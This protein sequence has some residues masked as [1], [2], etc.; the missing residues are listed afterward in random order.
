MGCLERVTE[1]L[2]GN[3]CVLAGKAQLKS[4]FLHSNLRT[5]IQ[6]LSV[7]NYVTSVGFSFLVCKFMIN[8]SSD[9]MEIC[10]QQVT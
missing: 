2:R 3:H 7:G 10:E 9:L 6:C 5:A 1:D 4:S 8:N